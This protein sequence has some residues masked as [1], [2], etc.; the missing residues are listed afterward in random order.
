MRRP[1]LDSR[2]WR[3]HVRPRQLALEPLCQ[4]CK[5][6]GIVEIATDVDHIRRPNGDLSLERD[7]RNHQS[8]CKSHHSS[9]TRWED[10]GGK[11]ALIVGYDVGGWPVSWSPKAGLH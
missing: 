9:K 10:A 6:L 5:A 8:L 2:V 7:E 11:G 1:F 4:W 3:E